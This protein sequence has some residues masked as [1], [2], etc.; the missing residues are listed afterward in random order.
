V[1]SGYYETTTIHHEAVYGERA[2]YGA[3]CS[4]CGANIS[5]FAVEHLEATGH[6]GYVTGVQVGTEGYLV[7]EAWDEEL[8]TWV[9]TS[10]WVHHE[11]YWG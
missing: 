6:H 4:D 9:D 10:H 8:R 7:Q 11:G 1:E 2:V 3:K 5:G